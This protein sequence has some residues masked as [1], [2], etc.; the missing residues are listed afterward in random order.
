M[1]PIAIPR[2]EGRY[3]VLDSNLKKKYG[4]GFL[5]QIPTISVNPQLSTSTSKLLSS[6]KDQKARIAQKV[7]SAARKQKNRGDDDNKNENN[8]HISV[9]DLGNSVCLT[10]QCSE[11]IPI[12][13]GRHTPSKD[14]KYYLIDCRPDSSQNEGK[15]PTSVSASS[16]MDPEKLEAL[17]SLFESL[18]G[19]VHICVMGEGFAALQLLYD[20]KP[21]R[22]EMTLAREDDS[23]TSSCALFF[24]K[25][26]YPFVSILDGG[27]A[28]AHAW[29]SRNIGGSETLTP[30]TVLVNYDAKV[31]TLAQLERAY[32]AS[33]AE[34]TQ[35]KLQYLLDNSMTVL[36]KSEEAIER[37]YVTATSAENRQ[38]AKEA[39]SK[40]SA[41][42]ISSLGSRVEMKRPA[43]DSAAQSTG[44]EDE[45]EHSAEHS[46]RHSDDNVDDEKK[47]E[48][49]TESNVSMRTNNMKMTFASFSSS[50]K[51]KNSSGS[52]SKELL[53]TSTA[54]GAAELSN[55]AAAPIHVDVVPTRSKFHFLVSPKPS[56]TVRTGAASESSTAQSS[57]QSSP[58]V[59]KESDKVISSRSMSLNR[60]S[61]TIASSSLKMS[62]GSKSGS[63]SSFARTK[64]S[65]TEGNPAMTFNI[66]SKLKS[67]ISSKPQVNGNKESNEEES[68]TFHSEQE[69][70]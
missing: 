66:G 16:L 21:T 58:P 7:E 65:F 43:G 19:A 54:T 24:I 2:Y 1:Y 20:H 67:K 61:T 56:E 60:I 68:I 14:L 11:V 15:F 64:T 6:V 8:D 47:D 50:V 55:T 62:F 17:E 25:R 70:K 63:K 53:P 4:V 29:L 51:A 3:D 37:R 69:E 31:S 28:A 40:Q 57:T 26:G 18:R 52:G 59:D 34:R 39:I 38:K 13:C 35:M 36:T 10:V 30:S 23:L 41:K 45:A 49:E 9:S 27:F 33:S 12:I 48:N 22:N 44:H 32:N 46:S 42:L 5:P